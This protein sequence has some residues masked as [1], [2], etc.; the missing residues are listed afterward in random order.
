MDQFGSSVAW[1]EDSLI[2]EA[3]SQ[4]NEGDKTGALYAF[5]KAYASNPDHYYLADFI[6]HLE[7][8]QSEDYERTM[9]VL[10]TYIG[11]YSDRTIFRKDNNLYYKN[12]N[13]YIYK[14]LPVS[15]YK[16]M[17]PSFYNRKV[18][19]IRKNNSI[20]GIKVI[21]RDGKEEFFSRNN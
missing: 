15:Q 9:P 1:K 12:Y 8:I 18:Q 7:F 17:M 5:R 11:K 16:F 13:G 14:L 3:R 10:D 4:L 2:I 20:E 6:R 19:I 21:H